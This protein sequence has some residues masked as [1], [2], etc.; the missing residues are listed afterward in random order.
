MLNRTNHGSQY[1]RVDKSL[2]NLR[3]GV[4][5][6]RRILAYGKDFVLNTVFIDVN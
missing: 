5:I 6:R 3:A 2:D 4:E 1:A